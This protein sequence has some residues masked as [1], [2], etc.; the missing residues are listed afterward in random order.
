MYI[1][2][3][4]GEVD[5]VASR[6]PWVL[7]LHKFPSKPLPDSISGVQ[8]FKIFLGH[9]H[10]WTTYRI[11]GCQVANVLRVHGLHTS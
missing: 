11:K 5:G 8:I 9:A 6:P 10:A 7:L 4:L 1:R 2:D 3:W